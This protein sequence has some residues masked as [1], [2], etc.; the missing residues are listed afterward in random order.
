MEYRR[1]IQNEQSYQRERVKLMRD[2]IENRKQQKKSQKVLLKTLQLQQDLETLTEEYKHV[3][4][5]TG[6]AHKLACDVI[7]NNF[8]RC[9]IQAKK[10][11]HFQTLRRQRAVL[12]SNEVKS[13]RLEEEKRENK[14]MQTINEVHNMARSHREDAH[15]LAESKRIKNQK[16]VESMVILEDIVFDKTSK[17]LQS[18]NSPAYRGSVAV[19]VKVIKHIDKSCNLHQLDQQSEYFKKWKFVMN[20]LVSRKKSIKRAKVAYKVIAHNRNA[21]DVEEALEAI[22]QMEQKQY[23]AHLH[24]QNTEKEG[25][26]R[27]YAEKVFAMEFMA[28]K[29]NSSSV[30]DIPQWNREDNRLTLSQDDS[31]NYTLESISSDDFKIINNIIPQWEKDDI[32]ES[33]DEEF[34]SSD[35]KPDVSIAEVHRIY[36][37]VKELRQSFNASNN[38]DTDATLQNVR[39]SLDRLAVQMKGLESHD[40]SSDEDI[41]IPTDANVSL[42]LKESKASID[43]FH[44]SYE[45]FIVN[46]SDFHQIETEPYEGKYEDDE[47]DEE[48]EVVTMAASD[49]IKRSELL[50][51]FGWNLSTFAGN[52]ELLSTSSSSEEREDSEDSEGSEDVKA[53]ELKLD[54]SI[55]PRIIRESELSLQDDLTLSTGLLDSSIATEAAR[56]DR[57]DFVA[58]LKEGEFIS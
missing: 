32:H 21:V 15:N 27:S 4:S 46:S 2:F 20:E 44:N 36:D 50:A 10:E 6:L 47:E 9:H 55:S 52:D 48:D 51:Q 26:D 13:K 31:K 29:S 39:A 11:E 23:R 42:D 16:S 12:A 28:G 49:V 30:Q 3:V 54:T 33:N 25:R 35:S 57:N 1:V 37:E 5:T 14:F 34:E 18:A 56:H 43:R 58:S 8:E 45:E 40:T 53:I 41:L 22:H 7:K 24:R 19:N 17:V 38:S